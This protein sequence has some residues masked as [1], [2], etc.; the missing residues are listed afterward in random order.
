MLS[1]LLRLLRLL[2]RRKEKAEA[3]RAGETGSGSGSGEPARSAAAQ[4]KAWHSSCSTRTAF[5][6]WAIRLSWV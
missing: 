2:E 6:R 3:E 1:R 4:M 5:C